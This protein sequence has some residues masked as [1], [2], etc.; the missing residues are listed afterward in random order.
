MDQRAQTQPPTLVVRPVLTGLRR[1]LSSII[2][3]VVVTVAAVLWGIYWA[4]NG[5]YDSEEIELLGWVVL[6]V[7]AVA[8]GYYLVYGRSTIEVTR[9]ELVVTRLGVRQRLSRTAVGGVIEGGVDYKNF[10]WSNRANY[11]FITDTEGERFVA[12]PGV[13]WPADGF[14]EL[15][16]ALGTWAR[17]AEGRDEELALTPWWKQMPAQMTVAGVALIGVMLFGWWATVTVQGWWQLTTEKSVQREFVAAVEP[18]L[19][20]S[21]F[22][23]LAERNSAP[24]TSLDVSAY[25][26]A[27]ADVRLRPSV[28]LASTDSELPASEAMDLLDLQCGY[29]PSGVKVTQASVT[30]NSDEDTWFDRDIEFECGADPGPLRAWLTW[31]EDHPA[32]ADLGD[33]SVEHGV[34]YDGD[35]LPLQI[36]AYLPDASDDTFRRAIDHFCAYPAIDELDVT[37]RDED[38]TR[39]SIRLNCAY[40]EDG[41][42]QE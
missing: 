16:R 1:I 10:R 42:G 2:S 30:Y 25:A 11:W 14:E 28:H 20:T 9:D 40:P 22:P 6:G 26:E 27:G 23:H 39:S 34:G 5:S 29:S 19:T 35:P 8:T 12:L 38:S 17:P 37:L 31:V 33:R 7:L 41:L 3:V 21:T 18:Q 13:M 4:R 24:G 32:D 36:D 15:A